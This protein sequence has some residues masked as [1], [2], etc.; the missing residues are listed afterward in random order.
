MCLPVGQA[1]EAGHSEIVLIGN[2][3]HACVGSEPLTAWVC[4]MV[5]S[6]NAEM[7]AL[8]DNAGRKKSACMVQTLFRKFFG[9]ADGARTRDPRRDRPVF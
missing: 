4:R 5:E 3:R 9:G 2:F 1:I 8:S 6:G 7:P